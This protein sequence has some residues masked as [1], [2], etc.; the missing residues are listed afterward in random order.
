[1]TKPLTVKELAAMRAK[2][3]K[4][5]N[6]R[7]VEA[8][9]PAPAGMRYEIMDPAV[10][11]FGVR[12]TDKGKRTYV[13]VG[14]FPG[15]EHPTRREI[16]EVG[17]LTLE[18]AH[19]EARKWNALIKRGID[20]RGEKERQRQAELRKQKHTFAAVAEEYLKRHVAKQR[21]AK[22]TE[23][24]I[25]AELLPI[26]G[27]RPIAEITREEAKELLRAII[28]RP[29][30]RMAELVYQHLRGVFAWAEKEGTY[31]LEGAPTDKIK[32]K[33]FF[34]ERKPRTRVLSDDELRAFWRATERMGYPFG[35]LFQLLLLTGCRETEIGSASWRE[36]SLDRTLLRVPAA[37]FK[38]EVE[39]LVPLSADACALLETLPR[40][41]RG[42]FMFT[43]RYGEAPVVNYGKAKERLDRYMTEELGHAPEPFRLHDLRRTVR[44]RL[45]SLRVAFEV[46]EMVI[47]HGKRGNQR[48]Y[49][50]HQYIDEI[51]ALEMWAAKLRSFITPPPPN[52]VQGQFGD[53]RA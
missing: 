33:L 18:E 16:A 45:S 4:A 43:A 22:K 35:P 17:K 41:T 31:G 50:Q 40:F 24:A 6:V 15:S 36:I 21:T 29:A 2:P 51:G 10:P 12:V 26:L 32:P 8:L 19:T 37:R 7:A 13:L 52:V 48:T 34:G 1:M 30:P 49:D 28:D 38:S 42:D 46:A 25:R 47:G 44:T 11:G 20:P 27:A 5:L 3:R 39:H 53:R 23:R 14:R 9:R